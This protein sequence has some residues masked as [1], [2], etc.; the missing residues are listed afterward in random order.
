MKHIQRKYT[1]TYR[2]RIKQEWDS[3]VRFGVIQLP[4]SKSDSWNNGSSSRNKLPWLHKKGIESLS[5][6]LNYVIWYY[7]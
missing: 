2:H 5:F 7:V 6:K 1:Y 4:L 3:A